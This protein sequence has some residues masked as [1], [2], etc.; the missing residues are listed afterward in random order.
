MFCPN[1]SQPNPADAAACSHCQQDTSTFRQR[2][3]IG[4]QFIFVQADDQHPVAIKVDGDVRTFQAPAILSRHRHSISFGDEASPPAGAGS[5]SRLLSRKQPEPTLRPLPDCSQFPSPT[6]KLVTVVSD[7]KIYQPN[8]EATLFIVAPDAA[9]QE[10]D[11]AVQLAGQK[12]FEAKVTL[13]QD[14]LALH[15]Y[16]D[17]KEGEYTAIVT[18]PDSSQADCTFSVAEFTLSPLIATLEKHAYAQQRLSFSLNMLV[19]SQPYSGPAEFGLQCKVCG[20]RVVATQQVKVEKGVAHGEFD[21]SGHGGP[22]HVQVTTPDGNTALVAFPGTGASEREHINLNTLGQTA[23][24]GLLPWEN[25]RPVRGFY[26]APGELN[27]TPLMLENVQAQSARLQVASDITLVQIVMFDPRQ[28]TREVIERTHLTR[29]DT[30][31]FETGS[32]YSLFTVAAFL[33]DG[34]KAPFEGWG[35]VIKPVAFEASLSSVPEIARPGEEIDVYVEIP[36]TAPDAPP[37]PAFCWLLVYDARLEHESPIPR[38]AKQI[39]ESVRVAGSYLTAGPVVKATDARWSSPADFAFRSGAMMPAV[40]SARTPGLMRGVL[41][42]P[43]PP[44][45]AFAA[46]PMNPPPTP[47]VM[48]KSAAVATAEAETL[49]FVMSPT[50]MEFP[51]LAYQELFHFAGRAARTVRLGDQIG[52]WR[53]RAYVFK[54]VDYRELT[55][56]VQADKP[57][58]AEFD[59]PAIASE[60]DEI[61]AAVDY[62]S[63]ETAELSIATPYG[64]KRLQVKGSGK[65]RFTIRGP[66]RVELNL[67]SGV[68]SDMSARHV[69]RPGVQKVTASRLLILDRGETVAGQRVAVYASMG[70]VLKE[71]ITALTDYPFG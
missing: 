26:L 11:L 12:V 52:T 21:I 27:M 41:R 5:L 49:Q 47:T 37:T 22:F 23:E 38:L 14:G 19:L 63:R 66:G 51:E 58:Y 13:N 16:D 39:Y 32:P 30:V 50:R 36:P 46:S 55:V 65:E 70:Q 31:E 59:L 24:M 54:G 57:V 6:L 56:D 68:D 17:L 69:A 45:M 67:H 1:C 2:L 18:L 42:D 44:Q 10:I 25:S 43:G 62:Y 7:R 8:N 4:Q 33:A 64:E 60:G 61:S 15:A 34:E 28:G 48:A 29:G 53:I 3:F 40:A 35:L 9:G 20:D 71:T